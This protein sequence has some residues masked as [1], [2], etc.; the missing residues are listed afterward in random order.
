MR[1]TQERYLEL[2]SKEQEREEKKSF[3]T[4]HLTLT[5]VPAFCLSPALRKGS[6][7][8]FFTDFPVYKKMRKKMG[9]EERVANGVCGV[10]G[11]GMT[12]GEVQ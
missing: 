2:K 11:G 10:S 12:G 5:L 8:D 7:L 1:K 4:I 9:P 3:K 6:N